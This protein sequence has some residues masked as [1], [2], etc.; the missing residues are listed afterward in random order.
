[1]SSAYRQFTSRCVEVWKEEKG[2]SALLRPLQQES[3][4]EWD[5]LVSNYDHDLLI[6]AFRLW[7][8]EEGKA[9]DPWALAKFV[10][11]AIKYAQRIEPTKDAVA[12]EAREKAVAASIERQTKTLVANRDKQTAETDGEE[13]FG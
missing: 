2:R 10:R 3:K 4:N 1:M 6:E 11:V 12:Q 13:L 9:S 8:K 7:A 5:F